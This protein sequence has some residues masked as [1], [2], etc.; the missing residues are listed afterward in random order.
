MDRKERKGKCLDKIVTIEELNYLTGK[1]V[2]PRLWDFLFFF[3]I[4][5]GELR[6]LGWLEDST[7]FWFFFFWKDG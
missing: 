1:V 7:S 5:R 4:S 2:D 3:C 6:G